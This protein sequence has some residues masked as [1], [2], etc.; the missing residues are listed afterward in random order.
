M[1]SLSSKSG[2]TD[3]LSL[4]E[5]RT[6]I[7]TRRQPRISKT[8]TL[9][10]NV[11]IDFRGYARGDWEKSIVAHID[12]AQEAAFLALIENETFINLSDR[13]GF[14]DGIISKYEIN[15]GDL[16]FTFWVRS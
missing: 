8:K 12:E 3:G 14:F 9:N 6:S 1:I 7:L 15:N 16:I 13:T 4:Q 2:T 5:K 11:S 10:G